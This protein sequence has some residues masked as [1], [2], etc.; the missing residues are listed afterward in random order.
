MPKRVIDPDAILDHAKP[1]T[2]PNAHETHPFG[3][4]V[5]LPIALAENACKESARP[6]RARAM[7]NGSEIALACDMTFVSREKEV[8][9][10]GRSQNARR[11][12]TTNSNT[13]YAALIVRAVVADALAAGAKAG[14]G[15][16]NTN[17]KVDVSSVEF[18]H[19]RTLVVH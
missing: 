2:Q 5:T 10:H 3:R 9:S 1:V 4:I 16:V 18:A 6:V 12:G 13:D 7:G 8:M 17:N 11:G 19:E 14:D 15:Y